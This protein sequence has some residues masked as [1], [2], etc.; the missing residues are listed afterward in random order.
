MKQV[1]IF[2]Y[3]FSSVVLMGSC[4][5]DFLTL[6][7]EGNLNEGNFYK[8]TLDFQQ[9]VNGAYVPLRDIANNAYWMD[10]MRSDNAHYD[11]NQKDRGNATTE[12]LVDF[13]DQANNVI[14]QNRYQAAYNGISRTNVILDRLAAITFA[15]SDAD[16]KQ[17]TGEAK[18][19]RGHYYFDL[20]RNFGG[21]PLHLHEVKNPSDAFVERSSAE[22]VY[23]Q[24]IADLT[25]AAGLLAAPTFAAAQT[26]RVTKGSV[27][28]ELAAVYM[29]RKEYNKAIPLL[30]SVTQMGYALMPNFRD[31]FNP[32]NKNGNKEII[33]DVQFQS[34]TTGQ[35]SNFIYRFTPVT[36]NTLNI[37]GVS[38]NNTIGGWNVPTESLINTYEAGDTRFD[39]TIGVIE[40]TLDANT[41]FTPTRVVS[42]VGY[43]Q[44]AGVV[45]KYFARKFYYPP[46]PNLNQNTDQNWPL[47]RY[48]DV[49]LLL[50]EALNET[51]KSTEALTYL[52]QVRTR[53]FGAGNGQITTVDQAALRTI[54][55]DERRRELAFEN[56]RWQDLIRT[57]Q[58]IQVMTAYGTALKLKYPYLLPQSYNVTQDRLLYPIPLREIQL[59]AKL[60][61][62]PGY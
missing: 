11:Y 8:S 14:T 18:A 16:K 33:W 29:Q 38:F 30:Q 40:G 19:L 27:T 1:K 7:P 22:Q 5:K 34:G 26:G 59:N 62:N 55:A 35:Q 48:S 20:V 13:L 45:A 25:E 49:L 46:Y 52:N 3:L 39:A 42:A 54:I 4:K 32:A 17:I 21:V 24:I 51:G 9:A 12:N 58:A 47:Y 10:E 44:P 31:V 60:T 41:N 2:L 23:A 6:Y 61:Q 37:L 28:T 57:G 43:T 15:M 36:T 50:A 53:A 56:K